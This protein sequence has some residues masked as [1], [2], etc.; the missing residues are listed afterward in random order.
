MAAVRSAVLSARQVAQESLPWVRFRAADPHK[1]PIDPNGNLTSKTEGSDSWTYAWNAENQLTKVEKNGVEQA[2]FAYDPL[3][4]RVEKV[5]GGVTTSYVFDGGHVAEEKRTGATIRYARASDVDEWLSRENADGSV[6]YFVADAVGNIVTEV[7]G[8]GTPTL[9]RSYGPWGNLDATSSTVGGPSFTG[10]WWEP[11]VQLYDYRARWYDSK[12][13]RFV[14]EDPVAARGRDLLGMLGLSAAAA[15]W[16]GKVPPYTYAGNDPVNVTDPSGLTPRSTRDCGPDSPRCWRYS[17]C[18][19][20]FGANAQCFCRCAGN[21][22]WSRHVRCCLF[23]KFAAG[24]SGDAAHFYCY[25]EATFPNGPPPAK[26]LLDCWAGCTRFQQWAC[27][28]SGSSR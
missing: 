5:A 26:S 3:W 23:E 17:P 25:A 20:Y 27:G 14:S 11:D 28:C 15:A 7:S 9:L 18:Y 21:D 19:S 8:V 10:R 13:G 12:I 1:I 24:W 4:R 22:P 6:T 16:A 2:R